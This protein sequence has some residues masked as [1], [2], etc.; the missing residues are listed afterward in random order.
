MDFR[1]ILKAKQYAKWDREKNDPNWGQLNATEDERRA[2]LRDTKVS[3]FLFF[4]LKICI[5]TEHLKKKKLC[6]CL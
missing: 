5:S 1:A 3:L 2:S 4:C 6:S